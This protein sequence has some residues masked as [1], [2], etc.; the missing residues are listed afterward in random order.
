[1]AQL[2]KRGFENEFKFKASKSGG[3]GG[4]HV[5]KVMTKIE[6]VFNVPDSQ[7]LT[8]DEK[9]QVKKA[10]AHK[11]SS[12][13]NL[14]IAVEAFRSQL[15]NKNISIERF[16]RLMENALRKPKIRK[17]TEPSKNSIE[18]RYKTKHITAEKKLIRKKI[19]LTSLSA[20]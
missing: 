1:M 16:Y 6:L 4:Q 13:G 5:N 20:E 10:L 3:K 2:N 11:L 19:S 7:V 8:D 18:K 12:R 17:A 14:R 15:K 9:V